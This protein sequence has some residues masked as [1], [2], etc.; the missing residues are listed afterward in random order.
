MTSAKEQIRNH[1]REIRASLTEKTIAEQSR[2]I[3][4]LLLRVLDGHDP[5]ML[6]ASKPSEVDTHPLIRTLLARGTRVIVPIIEQETRSL[7]LSYLSDIRHLTPSTFSVP[8]PVSHEIP[9][10]PSD[11]AA[12]VVPMIA[13]DSSGHRIGYGAGYY[14]RFLSRNRSLT[15]IGIAFSCL[16][17]PCIP[18]DPNDIG[19]DIL[20]TERG[21]RR[22]RQL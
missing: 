14:D 1:A 2:E 11:L 4:S 7:R 16:E 10:D 12:V 13:F 15:K 8:E 19:M 5:V 21:V 3:T 9:A 18:T 17:V 6:Y 20:V 22:F